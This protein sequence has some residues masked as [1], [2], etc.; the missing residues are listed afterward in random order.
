MTSSPSPTTKTQLTADDLILM[1]QRISYMYEELSME[2][3]L[4]LFHHMEDYYYPENLFRDILRNARA[5]PAS[6][7]P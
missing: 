4:K 1:R 3:K 6:E 7:S 2:D 5:S